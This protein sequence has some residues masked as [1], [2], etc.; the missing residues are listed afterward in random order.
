MSR[1][2]INRVSAIAPV[3][4]SLVALLIVLSAVS[5]GWERNLSDEGAAAHIFQLLIVAQIP[6]VLAFLVTANWKRMMQVARPLALQILSIGIAVG[7][8]AYF[9]L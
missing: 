6:F 8:V 5:A 1:Q 9:R 2:K 7:S 3:G 4:T